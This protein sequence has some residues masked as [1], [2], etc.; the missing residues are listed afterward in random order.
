MALRLVAALL[1]DAMR[2]VIDDVQ[3]GDVLLVQVIDRVRI[4]LAEDRHQH[5]G[6]G[7][8]LLAGGLHVV[9]RALQ[10]ALESQRRLGVAA[11]VVDRASTTDLSIACSSSVR[12]RGKSVPLA[13]STGLGRRVVEQRQQQVLDRHVLVARLAGALVAL[14][15]AVFEIFAEHGAVALRRNHCRRCG[16]AIP[17]SSPTLPRRPFRPSPSCTT[18]GA[19]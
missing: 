14:A 16:A 3:P 5:V 4:L 15:D 17:L 13:L 19:G 6:A 7:D 2:E 9:D 18:T 1:G 11:V 8:F 12:R 10:H